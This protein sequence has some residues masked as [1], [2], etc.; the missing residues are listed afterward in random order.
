M[1]SKIVPVAKK[2]DA[3]SRPTTRREMSVD[4]RPRPHHT[5]EDIA[6]IVM[7]RKTPLTA[8]EEDGL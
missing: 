5:S 3:L 6:S 4:E 1:L 2:S 7:Y 8:L